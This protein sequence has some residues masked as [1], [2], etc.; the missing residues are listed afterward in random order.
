MRDAGKVASKGDGGK[1]EG[2]KTEKPEREMKRAQGEGGIEKKRET[3]KKRLT[4]E[5]R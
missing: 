1:I 4:E 2:M 3:E 5:D